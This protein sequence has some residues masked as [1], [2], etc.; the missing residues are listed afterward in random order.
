MEDN[1]NLNFVSNNQ[2]DPKKR[3]ASKACIYCNR[4]HMS[5]EDGNIIVQIYFLI[6]IEST[7]L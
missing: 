1:N 4:S 3:R 2:Q 5:C 6:Y 7:S